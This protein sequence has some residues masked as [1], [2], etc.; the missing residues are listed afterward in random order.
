M[1][2]FVMRLIGVV[3]LS[4]IASISWAQNNDNDNSE[5]ATRTKILA[6][7]HAWNHAEELGDLRALDALLDNDLIYINFD[8]S[9]M[10][11]AE[12]LARAKSMHPQRMVSEL[13][14]VEVFEDTAVVTGT[15][16]SNEFKNGKVIAR[17]CRFTNIWMH[18]GSTWACIAAQATP[19]L[20]GVH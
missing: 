6:L 8:G 19:I 1:K 14:T 7:Q 10:T 16:R 12:V 17:T 2:L 4:A 11:K 20:H 5:A 18:K 13:M 3:F 9:L 15:Y